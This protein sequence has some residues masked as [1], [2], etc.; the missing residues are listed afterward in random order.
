MSEY[1][2][3]LFPGLQTTRFQITS[4]VD[5]AYNCIA[6]AA[7]DASNYWWPVGEAAKIFW[8]PT[9]PP[10]ET[11]AAFSAIFVML[12][13]VASAD[14]AL[15]PGFEKVALFANAHEVPTHAARQ[16]SSG[17][18]TSKLGRAEDIEHELHALEGEIYGA[19]AFLTTA[20]YRLSRNK[21]TARGHHNRRFSVNVT[22]HI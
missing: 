7:N 9:V 8:P 4:P 17:L 19:V 20:S 13:Y 6:W 10:E 3:K 12:G 15:E 2:Q 21:P 11:L 16:L 22:S 14:E 1:L 5:P 18:W